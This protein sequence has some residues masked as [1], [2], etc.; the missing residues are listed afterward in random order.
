MR[1][2]CPTADVPLKGVPWLCHV[3]PAIDRAVDRDAIPGQWASG[4][5][6]V[7]KAAARGWRRRSLRRHGGRSLRYHDV[8]GRC[9]RRVSG[10]SQ[11]EHHRCGNTK[12]FHAGPRSR[13]VARSLQR[14]RGI[15]STPFKNRARCSPRFYT[16]T[17]RTSSISLASDSAGSVSDY[18]NLRSR[19]IRPNR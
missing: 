13:V 12:F 8:V 16:R 11:S 4:E 19:S 6:K 2:S 15:T 9:I 1:Y 18:A 17:R 7:L 3:T 5:D 10:A 14:G